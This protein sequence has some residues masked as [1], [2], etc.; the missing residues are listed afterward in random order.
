MS[1]IN[2]AEQNL[3][4]D[5]QIEAIENEIRTLQVTMPI[6]DIESMPEALAASLD[7]LFINLH[8]VIALKC[9]STI[10]PQNTLIVDAIQHQQ[11]LKVLDVGKLIQLMSDQIELLQEAL[12]Q[13]DRDTQSTAMM[14]QAIA[15][16]FIARQVLVDTAI[17]DSSEADNFCQC[18]SCLQ[19]TYHQFTAGFDYVCTQCETPFFK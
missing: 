16:F 15:E 18:S 13:F 2:H 4:Y 7:E 9:V 10:D 14:K 11:A 12:V 8:T 19:S 6:G 1:F 3:H 17:S 5:Q